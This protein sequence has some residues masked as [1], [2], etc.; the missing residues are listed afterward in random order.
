[1]ART[2][3]PQQVKK[4]ERWIILLIG[5]TVAVTVIATLVT[6]G[7]SLFANLASIPGHALLWLA[8]ATLAANLLRFW[9]YQIAAQALHLHV[10]AIRMLYYY[11]VGYAL[12][13]TPGKLG[14]AIRLWLLKH[15]HN[16]PYHR[17][18]PLLVMDFLT[19]AIATFALA[20]FALLVG[21]DS[22]LATVGIILALGLAAGIAGT[23]LAPRLLM[24]CLK[25]LYWLTGRRKARLFARLRRLILTTANVLG[26]RM[27]LA[28]TTLSLA[29]WAILGVAIAHLV[30]GFGQQQISAAAGALSIT[31]SNIGGIITMMP[32]GVGGAE[33]TMAGIFKL[34][35]VPLGLAVLATAL[36]RLI[37]MWSTVL[38][39]LALLPFALRNVSRPPTGSRVDIRA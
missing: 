20:S 5:A 22:R 10:P 26:A 16:L 34:F 30:N 3:S 2:F 1:M 32:A 29:A 33:V 8:L 25:L 6:S 17:T 14:T 39:G 35:G 28:T 21:G 15:Y 31:L 12:I 37:V 11:T 18:A 9:R 4:A 27:L 7:R 24:H 23:L 38:I 19:D 13:P 36:T